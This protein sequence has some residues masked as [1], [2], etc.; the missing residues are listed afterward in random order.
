MAWLECTEERYPDD[1]VYDRVVVSYILC[2]ERYYDF[3]RACPYGWDT[4]C[5]IDGAC[6]KY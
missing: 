1:E 5:K 4:L 2:G 6:L 3:F